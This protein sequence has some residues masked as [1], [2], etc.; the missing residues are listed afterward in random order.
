VQCLDGLSGAVHVL[1]IA[2]GHGL[3]GMLASTPSGDAY[4]FRELE[5]MYL[6]ANFERISAHP[7]PTGPHTVVIGHAA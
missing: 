6:E 4:T 5:A 1:D 2:A 7:V 3:F